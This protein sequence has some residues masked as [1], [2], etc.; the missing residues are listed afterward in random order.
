[1]TEP[2]TTVI[3]WLMEYSLRY[4]LPL[5][6]SE[7]INLFPDLVVFDKLDIP[8]KQ[9]LVDLAALRLIA[10]SEE[11]NEFLD[12]LDEL[13]TLIRNFDELSHDTDFV[14]KPARRLQLEDFLNKLKMVKGLLQLKIMMSNIQSEYQDLVSEDFEVSNGSYSPA[15]KKLRRHCFKE[16]LNMV[17][18][19]IIDIKKID[20]HIADLKVE[21]VQ[22]NL[23]Q[24]FDTY[25]NEN[26]FKQKLT[27]LELF[28]KNRNE[29]LPTEVSEV[30]I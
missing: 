17:D 2:L 21:V 30:Q 15:C 6:K 20:T 11:T 23:I 13:K 22:H 25:A 24:T 16:M 5:L 10:S 19:K 14:K 12:N 18:G 26:V 9:T 28:I 29:Y 7:L 4:N 27:A 8:D 3:S 1:M